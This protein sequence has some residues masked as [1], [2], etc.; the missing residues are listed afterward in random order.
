MSSLKK[1]SD[2]MALWAFLN[3]IEEEKGLTRNDPHARHSRQLWHDD[4]NVQTVLKELGEH[5]LLLEVHLNITLEP[6]RKMP[7]RR[8]FANLPGTSRQQ[9]LP[10]PAS[11]PIH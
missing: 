11:R 5:R 4:V 9:G 6:R 10:C 7:Y 2:M 3:L 8:R 1:R